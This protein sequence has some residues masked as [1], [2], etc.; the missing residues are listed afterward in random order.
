MK[1]SSNPLE[2]KKLTDVTPKARESY[3]VCLKKP[4]SE[5]SRYVIALYDPIQPDKKWFLVNANGIKTL[6]NNIL[7]W[8]KIPKCNFLENNK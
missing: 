7:A 1:K 3:I 4:T 5:D 2:W 6:D 8:C